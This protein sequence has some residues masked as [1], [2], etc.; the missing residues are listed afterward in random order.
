MIYSAAH[1]TDGH[2]CDKQR[3]PQQPP[4]DPHRGAGA[5]ARA[6]RGAGRAALSIYTGCTTVGIYVLGILYIAICY[7]M[8][9]APEA[10]LAGTCACPGLD[11]WS[12]SPRWYDERP[13]RPRLLTTGALYRNDF[14]L[15]PLSQHR[16]SEGCEYAS[17]T[18]GT[19]CKSWRLPGRPTE[20]RAEPITA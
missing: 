20:T 15:P 3:H 2:Q 9:L 5:T 10:R 13:A 6:D 8:D 4:R 12:R 16:S 19:T 7:C 1:D 18:S 14:P 11:G 17:L